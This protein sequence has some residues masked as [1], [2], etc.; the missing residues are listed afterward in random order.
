MASMQRDMSGS[1]M[2]S[3]DRSSEMEAALRCSRPV[4][5]G[6]MRSLGVAGFEGGASALRAATRPPG[7]APAVCPGPPGNPAN[8]VFPV[9]RKDSAAHIRTALSFSY[10]Y[11]A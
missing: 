8:R 3:L 2:N 7:F 9:K 10:H 1:V 5:W 6:L 4:C 11:F